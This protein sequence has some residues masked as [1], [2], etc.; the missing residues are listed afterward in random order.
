MTTNRYGRL[1]ASS[2]N[3]QSM[4][5]VQSAPV[6][7]DAKPLNAEIREYLAGQFDEIR[8]IGAAFRL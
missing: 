1:S 6:T 5:A 8:R 7:S 4:P 2:P 3:T